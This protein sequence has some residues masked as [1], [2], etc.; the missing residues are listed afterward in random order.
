MVLVRVEIRVGNIMSELLSDPCESLRLITVVGIKS[1]PVTLSIINIIIA[2]V[3][4]FC[5]FESPCMAFMPLGVH[6]F[7]MPRMLLVK[8]MAIW[9]LVSLSVLPIRKSIIGLSHLESFLSKPVASKIFKSPSQIE[10]MLHNFKHRAIAFS[11][12]VWMVMKASSGE[13]ISINASPMTSIEI[14]TI[15]MF[16]SLIPIYMLYK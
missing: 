4:C 15:F 6:A 8:F 16:F 11:L 1:S 12:P 5:P 7:P 3:I 14:H 10:Y 9:F 13:R 2:L